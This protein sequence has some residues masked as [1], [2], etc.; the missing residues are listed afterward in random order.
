MRFVFFLFVFVL[1]IRG[2]YS[3]RFCGKTSFPFV[4][5]FFLLFLLLFLSVVFFY[6]IIQFVLDFFFSFF[7]CVCLIYRLNILS[8]V[9]LSLNSVTISACYSVLPLIG[10]SISY[11]C[12]SSN[13]INTKKHSN[14]K[15]TKRKTTQ[16]PFFTNFSAGLGSCR[17][18]DCVQ[19][20]FYCFRCCFFLSNFTL[21]L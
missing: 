11:L 9:N 13:W 3:T 7:L 18:Y 15:R 17:R 20:T 6:W 14:V 5:Y 21:L 10:D 1:F 19:N 16:I 8:F 4:F 2:I 12:M